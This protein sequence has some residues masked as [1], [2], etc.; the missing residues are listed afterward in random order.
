MLLHAAVSALGAARV[1][2]VTADS[3]SL[4][5]PEL[6][7][8]RKLAALIGVRHLILETRELER[9]GYT[10]NAPDRCYF[11]KSELFD[12]VAAALERATESGWPV[13]YGAITDDASDH[14]PGARAAK[15]RNVLAP[16]EEA[17]FSKEDVRRYSRDH[18]LPTADKPSF[19][20]LSSR[21]QHGIAIDAPLL[22][23]IETAEQYLRRRGFVQFRVRH[24][25]TWARI[26]LAPAEIGRAAG[27]EREGIVR[28]LKQLGYE[29][30]TLDLEGYRT[31]SMNPTP[32]PPATPV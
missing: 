31:G 23:R 7:D 24:H 12:V 16:L 17:G 26:E 25:D 15:E 28:H 18:A 13:L 10:R 20:C 5:R 21:V 29:R 9:E 3:P 14:R 30:V 32:P 27:E 8:T 2:A 22:L 1:L 11:C 4:P 19:A 6:D